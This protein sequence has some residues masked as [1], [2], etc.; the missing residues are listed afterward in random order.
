MPYD[1]NNPPSKLRGLSEKKQRQWVEVF[2][3]CYERHKDD[4]LCHKMAWG[5]VKKCEDCDDYGK[6]LATE[7]LFAFNAAIERVVKES[8]AGIRRFA[9]RIARKMGGWR[10]GCRLS[11]SAHRGD[12]YHITV[13][14]DAEE[15]VGRRIADLRDALLS[16]GFKE[17]AEGVFSQGNKYV[18]QGRAF[19]RR[20]KRPMAFMVTVRILS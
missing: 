18:I 13:V 10:G 11:P 15:D 16:D 5:V 4:A 14:C 2:N 12:T 1:V 6:D 3:S 7:E 8:D 20:G 9:S 19:R 17:E